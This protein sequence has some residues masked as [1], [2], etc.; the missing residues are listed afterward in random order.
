MDDW[1]QLFRAMELLVRTKAEIVSTWTLHFIVSW[2]VFLNPRVGCWFVRSPRYSTETTLLLIS[3][4]DKSL[5]KFPFMN[6]NSSWGLCCHYLLLTWPCYV[7]SFIFQMYCHECSETFRF[8]LK[9]RKKK[10]P[11]NF[12]YRYNPNWKRKVKLTVC[13]LTGF[14]SRPPVFG[15][16][17]GK[18]LKV[19]SKLIKKIGIKRFIIL[20]NIKK[21]LELQL[22]ARFSGQNWNILSESVIRL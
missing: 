7:L 20:S 17:L 6:L 11:K 8:N 9:N 2:N 1:W 18:S 21:R 16:L 3:S 22:P 10:K 15:T 5:Y 4:L 19:F 14:P 13:A 12:N